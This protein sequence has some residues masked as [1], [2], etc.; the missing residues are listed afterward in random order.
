MNP[1]HAAKIAGVQLPED[2][3]ERV[4]Q[5]LRAT[6]ITIIVK[7]DFKQHR[8]LDSSAIVASVKR[9]FGRGEGRLEKARAVEGTG[10]NRERLDLLEDM[11]L[12]DASY[13][14]AGPGGPTFESHCSALMEI[15][16]RVKG[17]VRAQTA[18]ERR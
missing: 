17:E 7:A 10:K 16:D 18:K 1:L 8:F 12:A 11:T 9:W 2:A 6:E 13:L 3:T 14:V 5:E 4:L 15:W